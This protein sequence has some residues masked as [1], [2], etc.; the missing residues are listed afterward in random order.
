[1]LLTVLEIWFIRVFR[2][3][4]HSGQLSVNGRIL[5][6]EYT[7]QVK[8]YD[9]VKRSEVTSTI[10]V[11]VNEI[12]DDA[13]LNSGSVRLQGLYA[14]NLCYWS[15]VFVESDIWKSAVIDLTNFTI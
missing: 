12:S 9:V 5:S 3:D 4:R 11:H 7:F 13:V 2:L 6:D 1:M 15:V 10:T 14:T 8:V